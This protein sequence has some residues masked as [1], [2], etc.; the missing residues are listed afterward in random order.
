MV[1]GIGMCVNS[2]M[3]L[4]FYCVV[5]DFV[6]ATSGLYICKALLASSAVIRNF[7]VQFCSSV[8]KYFM[9]PGVPNF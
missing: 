6:L 8:L 5:L 4:R 3:I 1:V 7:R 2:I 9:Y